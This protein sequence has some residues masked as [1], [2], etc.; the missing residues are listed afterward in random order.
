MGKETAKHPIDGLSGFYFLLT[1][2]FSAMTI[3]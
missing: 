2:M 3:H 1:S